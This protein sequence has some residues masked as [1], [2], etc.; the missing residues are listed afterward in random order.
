MSKTE[1]SLR[2][3]LCSCAEQALEKQDADG[4]M[5]A[6]HNGPWNDPETPVRNTGHWAITFLRS[7]EWTDDD[8]FLTAGENAVSYLLSDAARPHGAT[9]H[10]RLSDEKDRCNGL[11]GQAWSIE[12]LVVAARY[13]DRPE[14][15]EL[16]SDVFLQ[17]P[18]K[19]SL[20]AWHPVEIDGTVNPI[21]MT[22]NHQL[23]FAA[24]GG[25]LAQHPASD[26][27]VD[28]QVRRYLDDLQANLNVMDNGLVYHPFKPDFDVRKYGKIFFEGVKAGTAH[29]MVLGVLRGLLGGEENSEDA[30]EGGWTEKSVGYHSFN[31]YA[32]GLLREAYPD[33]SFWDHSKLEQTVSYAD[34]DVYIEALE[35]NPY[36]YPYNCAGIETAYALDV[37]TDIGPTERQRWLERQFERTY[38]PTEQGMTRNNPDPTTL[39]A[40]LYEATRLPETD[41]AI[42]SENP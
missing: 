3:I 32:F 37:F 18:F 13:L 16:A 41:V 22:F 42:R 15:V 40:R 28:R 1:Q 11:I 26:R 4:S 23:W 20:A 7:H 27:A 14:L 8:R 10:H 34:S 36:G 35:G 21:D 5:P 39:T 30:D 31:L 2:D 24:A 9:F 6:G 25:L 29:T 38:D 17:H 12:A 33:H 19:S